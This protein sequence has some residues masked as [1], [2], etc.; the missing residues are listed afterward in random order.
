MKFLNH[1]DVGLLSDAQYQEMTAKEGYASLKRQFY[2]DIIGDETTRGSG[3]AGRKPSSLKA[4]TGSSRTILAPVYSGVRNH[5]EILRKGLKQ[6]VDNQIVKIAMD[7]KLPDIFQRQQLHKRKDPE[8]GAWIYKQEKDPNIIMGRINGKRVPVL[9]DGYI[10]KTLD[11]LV[12]YE[13]VAFL[14][15]LLVGA[16][17]LFTSGTTSLFPGFTLTNFVIDQISAVA[18]TRH[19]FIPVY[20]PL[21]EL[22]K[23]VAKSNSSEAKYIQEYLVMAGERQTIM[24]SQGMSPRELAQVVAKEAKGIDLFTKWVDSGKNI[25]GFTQKWSEIVTRMSEYAKSRKAGN[26]QAQALEDAGRVTAPFHHIGRLGN[27]QML[28]TMVK[29]VPFFNAGLQVLE[30]TYRSG[31]KSGA[32]SRNRMLFVILALI[33]AQVAGQKL[34]MSQGTK[35]QKDEYKDIQPAELTKYLWL[36]H[37]SGKGLIKLRIPDQYA[38]FGAMI[39]MAIMDQVANTKY[40]Y[41]DYVTAGTSFIPRQLNPLHPGQMITSWIPQAIKPEL[42]IAL[43]FKDFPNIQQ[44]ESDSQLRKER[45]LR[46]TPATPAAIKWFGEKFNLSP[47]QIDTLIT[48]HFGRVTGFVTGKPGILNPL[49]S[50]KKEYYFESGRRLQD[51]YKTKD[52]NDERYNSLLHRLRP[53][54]P[55]ERLEVLKERAQLKVITDLLDDYGDLDPEKNALQAELI[56]DKILERIDKLP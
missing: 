5:A 43:N 14:T 38:Q 32:K 24:G 11:E 1:P 26:S 45:G 28:K 16:N 35:E 50:L 37:P 47:I 9:V 27:S 54:T 49:N 55:A 12:D 42:Q 46:S 36:P 2:D 30:Q 51:F 15:K 6:I 17:R 31:F 19:A 22:Y 56:R 21:K 52:S 29:S 53:F 20:T 44:L 7:D 40:T 13:S 34:I 33:A 3:I 18:Q 8:T 39:N 41:G 23:V 25:L 10:K 48:G 4:R